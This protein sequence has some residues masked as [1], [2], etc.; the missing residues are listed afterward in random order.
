M[1][2]TAT[3]AADRAVIT[4]T[5]RLDTSLVRDLDEKRRK[6]G[7]ILGFDVSRSDYIAH[8]MRQLW[9]DKGASDDPVNRKRKLAPRARR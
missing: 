4:F 1:P 8:G 2:T 3:S 6:L 7:D 9:G 5:V